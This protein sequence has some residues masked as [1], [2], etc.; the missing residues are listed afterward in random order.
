MTRER[1]AAWTGRTGATVSTG[2]IAALEAKTAKLERDM[3]MYEVVPAVARRSPVNLAVFGRL[4]S[5]VGGRRNPIHG[6]GHEYHEG[7]DIDAAWGT[8]VEAAAQAKSR[9]PAGREATATS[10]MSITAAAS[11]HVTVTFRNQCQPSGRSVSIGEILGLV[12]STGRSTGPHL[13]LRSA[14][15]QSTG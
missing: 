10:S 13:A 4:E 3:R 12:G 9:L 14:H 15:Q 1:S 11:R 7:Q 2:S 8:P 5:G 6:R